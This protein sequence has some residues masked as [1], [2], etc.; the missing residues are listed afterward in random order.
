VTLERQA[1][2]APGS[3]GHGA[4]ERMRQRYRLVRWRLLGAWLLVAVII[5]GSWQL[6]YTLHL[7][8]PLL[9]SGPG[10]SIVAVWDL[11][12]SG[13]LW[14]QLFE[15]LE[16]AAI[17]YA[18]GLFVGALLGLVI[19]TVPFLHDAVE[20]YITVLNSA[21]RLALGP[22]FVLWFGIG[23]RSGVAL[24]FSI[25]VFVA[26]TNT[27]AGTR[28]VDRNQLVIAQLCGANRLRQMRS[29][30]L[31]SIVPWLFAA[32][33][34]SLAYAL[35]AAIVSEMLLGNKGLGYL[36]VAGTGSFNMDTVFAVVLVT[37]AVSWFAALLLSAIERHVL[38][39]Q[40]AVSGRS[41]AVSR[42]ALVMESVR[43]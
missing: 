17:G 16:T 2:M 25:V 28:A 31:P 23:T 21:P 22:L 26:L 34:L 41:L 32:A 27:I 3:P 24:T 39:W 43:I 37:L 1:T 7:I 14:P 9:I 30:I 42:P 35:N 19:G 10:Q 8:N 18:L 40:P 38:R 29:I 5:V 15:T 11:M 20:P 13:V 33:R 6:A 12:T 4:A 36:I